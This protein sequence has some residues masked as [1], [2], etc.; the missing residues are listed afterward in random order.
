[1]EIKELVKKA[2][3]GN[4]E[5]F[6]ELILYYEKDLYNIAKSRLHNEDDV[7]DAVQETIL[8]AYKSIQKLI[9][10]SK[11]KFWLIKILINECNKIYNNQKNSSYDIDHKLDSI[12]YDKEDSNLEF[13]NLMNVLDSDEKNIFILYYQ[14]GYTSKEIS[15]IL[16]INQNTILSKL[17]RG[18][19]K[20][21]NTL[22]EV[23]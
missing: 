23:L 19:E 20:I 16:N 2:Q 12:V 7:C 4:K 8:I 18:K 17:S 3:K 13:L 14:E 15:Q 22:K 11:F 10:P 5:S 1:M 9:N 6:N 21:K